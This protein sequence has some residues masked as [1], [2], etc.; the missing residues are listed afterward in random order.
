VK[1]KEI[2]E[3][4]ENELR[5]DLVELKNKSTKLRFDV[6]AKQAKNHREVRKT[7]KDIARI[8]TV[9]KSQGV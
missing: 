4:S 2:R 1:I 6:S 9:L 5:K 7:K 8:Y 3:K